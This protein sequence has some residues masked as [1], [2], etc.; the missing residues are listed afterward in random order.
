MSILSGRFS[1]ISILRVRAQEDSRFLRIAGAEGAAARL[2]LKR[3]TLQSK[4][5]KLGITRL[6]F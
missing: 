4:M 2:G 5:P 1:A 3:T 6:G